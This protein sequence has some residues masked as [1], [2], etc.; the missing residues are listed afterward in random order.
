M[1]HGLSAYTTGEC[2][3][4]LCRQAYREYRRAN[5]AILR[6]AFARGET[7]PAVHNANTYQNWGCRCE[8]CTTANRNRNRAWRLQR[9][10]A[11]S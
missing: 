9:R 5:R 8:T 6:A 2:K 10:T 7:G 11:A 1:K 3:C 4:A